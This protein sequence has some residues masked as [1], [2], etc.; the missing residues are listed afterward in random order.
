MTGASLVI[1]CIVEGWDYSTE[2]LLKRQAQRR[3]LRQLE[4]VQK[5]VDGYKTLQRLMVDSSVE[6]IV[7]ISEAHFALSAAAENQLGEIALLETERMVKSHR[8]LRQETARCEADTESFRLNHPG[9]TIQ[10][11]SSRSSATRSRKHGSLARSIRSIR[12][13]RGSGLSILFGFAALSDEDGP[14]P[15]NDDWAERRRTRGRERRQSLAAEEARV[16]MAQPLRTAVSSDEEQEMA[17]APGMEQLEDARMLQS[18][19]NVLQRVYD[20]DVETAAPSSIGRSVSEVLGGALGLG[21]TSSTA[22]SKSITRRGNRTDS[23]GIKALTTKAS[24]DVAS[25]LGGT[26]VASVLGGTVELG[27]A[28][29]GETLQGIGKATC[30]GT[31]MAKLA[32]SDFLNDHDIVDESATLR[33]DQE[34]MDAAYT[35]LASTTA[36]NGRS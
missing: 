20:K 35:M 15:E 16:R 10:A 19:D 22:G 28:A 23:T 31:D 12:R 4:K 2:L 36:A 24:A 25:V 34:A 7:G 26:G 3:E 21:G 30:A 32:A 5:D 1:S 13:A 18:V 8:L 14:T 27:S 29:I 11:Q 17:P 33:R 9:S 6:D